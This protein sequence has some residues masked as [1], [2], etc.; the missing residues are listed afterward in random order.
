MDQLQAVLAA[1]AHRDGR[2]LP[3]ARFR[4]RHLV[5]APLAIALWQL[6]AEPFSA[7]AI[8][9]GRSEDDMRTVV[10]GDPRNRDMAFAALLEFAHWFNAL[11][12]APANDRE[13]VRE[14][15][16]RTITRA[17]TAPQVVV[18]NLATAEMLGRLGRRLAY[19]PTDGRRPADP[20][21][22]RLGRHLQF[23]GRHVLFPGQQLL[24]PMTEL[25]SDHYATG[26][27]AQEQMALPA[28]DAYIEPPEGEHGFDAAVRAERLSIGPVP[29]EEDDTLLEPLIQAL[30][31]ARQG[32]TAP[33]V[34]RP[35][36]A[37]IV[38]HFQPRL[39]DTWELLW[40]CRDREAAKEEAPSVA[41]RWEE[42][43]Q[44][45]TNHIDW[46]VG[47]DGR[48]KTRQ[49]TRQ[50][51]T[52]LRNLEAAQAR[53][54]AEEACD[55]PVRMLPYLLANK[56]VKG[57]VVWADPN[58]KEVAAVNRVRRPLVTLLSPDPCLMPAG[59]ELWWDRH[60]TGKPWVVEAIAPDPSGGTR[61][62]LK[63]TTGSGAVPAVGEEVCF[64]I[65]NKIA[66][67]RPELPEAVPW[68]H[69]PAAE[70]PA[71]QPLEDEEEA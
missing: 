13:L 3:T 48:R 37:P 52:T 32:S 55:D 30:H 19:L 24:V 12:E 21:L 35:L 15:D 5:A 53:L 66:P 2:A 31:D 33:A 41:R 40:R 10:A 17:R 36:L 59:K 60:P 54:L 27:S 29:T 43:R 16:K 1:R 9:F 11:F 63:L 50:A 69:R 44:A 18:A 46:V 7:A 68:T 67:Y 61:V 4:H 23:L 26:L 47:Q 25:L 49:T 20:A 6:G 22:V 62:T 28:L 64:S 57:E 8:G 58:H 42:D 39:A 14:D 45:Y 65:H 56:A 71:P 70:P 34:L 51:A 38:A